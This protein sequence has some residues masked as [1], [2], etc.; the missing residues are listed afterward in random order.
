[1]TI[2][3][4]EEIKLVIWDLDET[5]WDGTLSE[6]EIN[7]IPQ[8]IDRVE[9]LSK[10][11]VLNSICS[12]ND[13]NQAQTT[14]RDLGVWDFFVF[15]SITWKPKGQ[16]V[17][18]IIEL[19][20]LRV[21]N[22]L[23]VDDNPLNRAE[24]EFY[25]EGIQTIDPKEWD[26]IDCTNWGK[27]DSSLSRLKTYKLLEDKTR[28][29]NQYDGD[30]ENFLKVSQIVVTLSPLNPATDD[31]DRVVEL[32]NRTNQLN[33]TKRRF[34][35]G[36][37]QFLFRIRDFVST[38][39]T[40][41]VVDKYGDYGL[42]GFISVADN[43]RLTDFVFS[44]RLLDMGVERAILQHLT[45][46]YPELQIPFDAGA[47]LHDASWVE[48]RMAEKQN[49]LG[50]PALNGPSVVTP[51]A[52]FSEV[53]APFLEPDFAVHGM[54]LLPPIPAR[55]IRP[56]RTSSVLY[57][58]GLARE[59]DALFA[60]QHEFLFI[61]APVEVLFPAP[62]VPILGYFPIPAMLNSSIIGQFP[63]LQNHVETE[64][65][66]RGELMGRAMSTTYA[67]TIVRTILSLSKLEYVARQTV[68]TEERAGQDLA[69]LR[70]RLP[71][72]T[73]L[74]I[75]VGPEERTQSDSGGVCAELD[76]YLAEQIVAANRAARRLARSEPNV[77]ILEPVDYAEAGKSEVAGHFSHEMNCKIALSLKELLFQVC[78]TMPPVDD[79]NFR[80]GA[81]LDRQII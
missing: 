75:S 28:A 56:G 61:G 18:H 52:C 11:G 66:E 30:N 64:L 20:K 19:M 15:P 48:L 78:Q 33:F 38:A 24:I 7:S 26:L 73:Q 37:A 63:E 68:V 39:F 71:K 35:S 23:V 17:Q 54:P 6:G 32:L 21:V 14:L 79:P 25:N 47:L 45:A 5:F 43:G 3:K 58:S 9:L 81:A 50:A 1:M 44:C 53:L 36:I 2:S 34:P 77:V 55:A 76:E 12:K 42:C 51:A 16:Q 74:V 13:N 57:W 4:S 67:R 59:F 80:R 70:A 49:S 40:V 69:D 72:R 29:A 31:M 65:N 22:V 10:R 60:G 62:W 8:N 41:H 27:D 46:T